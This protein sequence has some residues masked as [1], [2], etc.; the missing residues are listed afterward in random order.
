M[1]FGRCAAAAVAGL[2]AGLGGTQAVAVPQ[3]LVFRTT[4]PDPVAAGGHYTVRLT[5]PHADDVV[6]IERDFPLVGVT[7]SS[8]GKQGTY[9]PYTVPADTPPGE[10]LFDA[11]CV[12]PSG[13]ETRANLVTVNVEAAASPTPTPTPTPTV[14][15]IPTRSP[16]ASPTDTPTLPPRPTGTSSRSA[17]PLPTPPKGGTGSH[18]RLA[19]TGAS[20]MRTAVGGTAVALIAAGSAVL[21]LV[22][23]RNRRH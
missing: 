3:D 19:E 22:R 21:L 9:G 18:P 15:P 4:D 8:H 6:D 5:C 16:A 13:A 12:S 7:A 10:H 14:K 17:A 11:F 20:T 23:R 2:L 1:A